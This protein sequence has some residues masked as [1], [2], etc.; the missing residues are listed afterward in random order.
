MG[1][2]LR[3]DAGD[4]HGITRRAV[5]ASGAGAYAGALWASAAFA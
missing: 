2:Q 3:D 1:R 5:I 4:G